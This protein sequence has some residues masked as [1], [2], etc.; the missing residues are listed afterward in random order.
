[1]SLSRMTFYLVQI[2]TVLPIKP[3]HL[4]TERNKITFLP[5]PVQDGCSHLLSTYFIY[6]LLAS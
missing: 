5:M 6:N 3:H 2:F 1:M 4:K